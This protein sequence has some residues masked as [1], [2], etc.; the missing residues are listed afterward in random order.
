LPNIGSGGVLR[1]FFSISDGKHTF[2]DSRGVELTG[3]AAARETARAQMRELKGLLCERSLH[4]WS[5]WKI[6]VTDD[7]NKTIFEIDSDL[8]L[9]KLVS[10]PPEAA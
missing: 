2:T 10:R 1:Y 9:M 8:K 7:K 4:G 3:I 5:D 6:I